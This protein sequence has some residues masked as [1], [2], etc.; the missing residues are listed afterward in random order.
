M[1]GLKWFV[2]LGFFLGCLLAVGG[3]ARPGVAAADE[4]DGPV[5]KTSRGGVRGTLER[6]AGGVKVAVFRGIPYAKAPTG[7]R[8]WAPPEEMGRWLVTR[9]ATHFGAA[10]A[11]QQ[12]GWND[13]F[14]A[15]SSEDCLYLNVWSTAVAA[16]RGGEQ[17]KL[18]VMVYVHGGGN[19]AGTAS[20]DLSNGLSLAPR[21]VLLVTVNY[22]VGVFGFLSAPELRSEK[23]SEGASGNYG[24]RDQ[25]AALTWVQQ[26]IGA[27]G[28]DPARVTVMGQSAG[29]LDVGALMASERA[30]G[31]F[32]GAIEESGTVLGLGSPATVAESEAAWAGIRAKLGDSLKAMRQH[33]TEEVLA[34]DHEMPVSAGGGRGLSGGRALSVDGWVLKE[35]PAAVF[36]A[37]REA[38]VPLVIG[39]NVQEI[40]PAG[41]SADEVR[42][43]IQAALPKAGAEALETVYGLG[44]QGAGEAQAGGVSHRLGDASARWATDE[45]F[46]CP[47]RAVARL[48][49][50]HD[51]PTWEYQFE[52]GLPWQEAAMHSTELFF[53][54]HYF[55]AQHGEQGEW[56][57]EDE[58]A[59]DMMEMYWTNFAKT[60]DPNKPEQGAPGVKW[61]QFTQEREGYL[62]LTLQGAIAGERLEDAACRLVP[63]AAK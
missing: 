47:A 3:W 2:A 63:V 52:P 24:L 11:Q 1:L 31:L 59:S 9:D 17:E 26:E 20:E 38:K 14:A 7:R 53:L 22:R 33:T 40:V 51:A 50:G 27:F 16:K 45:M 49:S 43:K 30:K 32:A 42:Q 25:I 60:G 4:N 29:A 37:G 15:E 18:P 19:Q 55:H 13:R 41:D 10:C 28:G 54:F 61:P 58:E 39:N 35:T 6:G 23:G 56:T 5:V 21:G 57:P 44:Q 46:R 36:A 34:A 12:Q 8:R 48:H 62:D